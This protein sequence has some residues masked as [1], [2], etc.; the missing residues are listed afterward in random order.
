MP[1]MIAPTMPAATRMTPMLIAIAAIFF[2]ICSRLSARDLL[3][4]DGP[5][6]TRRLTAAA[7]AMIWSDWLVSDLDMR[8][9]AS[10]LQRAQQRGARRCAAAALRGALGARDIALGLLDFLAQRVDRGLHAVQRLDLERVDIV[11][12]VVDVLESALQRLDGNRRRCRLFVD[13]GGLVLEH[14]AGRIDDVRGGGVERGDLVE[15]QLLP[16]QR[17]RD[18]DCGAQCGD[19]G[20]AGT[21][22]ALDQLNIVLL[23][24]T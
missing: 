21:V 19:G 1:S 3:P 22:D 14:R 20:G 11:H 9:P 6:W 2:H 7:S 10:S 4:I 5:I 12:R 18:G 13:L 23:D 24:Q 8:V 17:L 15:H 16:D